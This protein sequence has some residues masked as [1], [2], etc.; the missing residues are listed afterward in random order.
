MGDSK[1]SQFHRQS[2]TYFLY[3]PIPQLHEIWKNNAKHMAHNININKFEVVIILNAGSVQV[4]N[5]L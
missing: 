3:F 1:K 4:T 5:G 2:N